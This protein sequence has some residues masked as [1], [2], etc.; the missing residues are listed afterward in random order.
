MIEL[1]LKQ[2]GVGTQI[3]IAG[4]VMDIRRGFHGLAAQVQTAL[5]RA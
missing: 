4:G 1:P 5:D 3:W 2:H